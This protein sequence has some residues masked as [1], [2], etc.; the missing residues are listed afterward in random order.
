M[1]PVSDD[2]SPDL[3]EIQTKQEGNTY[4]I[5]LI[6]ELDLAGCN[7][8]EEALRQAEESK[9]EVIVLDIEQLRFIDSTGLSLLLRAKRRHEGDSG[10][11]R[12][13]RGHGH[14]SEMLR[15]TG[16]DRVLPFA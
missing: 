10:R 4:Y 9:A 7:E 1:P 3:L 15:I 5:H 2:P 16:L 6:G 12:V 11:L 8:T 13:T 14:V